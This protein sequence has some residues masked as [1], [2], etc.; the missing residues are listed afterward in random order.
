[1]ATGGLQYINLAS[2]EVLP[3]S[4]ASNMDYIGSRVDLNSLFYW[5]KNNSVKPSYRIYVLYPDETINYEIPQEDIKVGGS[6]SENYQNGQRRSLSFSLFNELGQ[7]T[8]NINV[9]WA[10]TRIR[11]DMGIELPSGEQIWVEK[12]IFVVRTTEPNLTPDDTS[13]SISCA[14]KFS[15]FEDKTGTLDV[16]YEVP[17]NSDIE[18]VVRDLLR[19]NMGDGHPFDTKDIVFHSSFKGAVT[20][21]TIE[22][23]AG[24]TI[25]SILLD[26][27]TQ[28]GAEVFYN[29]MGNLTFIPTN[30]AGLDADKPLLYDYEA[31]SA[32][33]SG[34]NFSFDLSSIVNRVIVIG[35]SANGGV[36]S[37]VAVNDDPGSPLCVQRI[38]YRTDNVINDSNIST[39]MLADER[40][41]Y[42]LRKRLV[43]KSSTSLNVVYNPL[44]TVN[45]LIA[46]SSEFYGLVHEKFLIQSVNYPLD[47]SGNIS[48]SVSNLQNLP[49][50]TRITH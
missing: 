17:V 40:A 42:E 10:G 35:S 19:M 48:V 24:D 22:K 20:Q 36:V 21:M 30:E 12:G 6:Y 3:I 4:L 32:D 28:L 7:Y 18:Q 33:T 13:V 37:A 2:G 41:R 8:P 47:Y 34:L 45:N 25:G 15:L 44:L 1:M 38:G 23:S 16:A 26:L 27:A 5:L 11:L 49:T 46:I 43:L 31:E 50:L 39:N 9:L 29:S 14:D